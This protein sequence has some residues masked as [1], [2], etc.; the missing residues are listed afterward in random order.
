MTVRHSWVVALLVT[1]CH[2]DASA[3]YQLFS[4]QQDDAMRLCRGDTT[5]GAAEC[6]TGTGEIADATNGTAPQWHG[7][8]ETQVTWLQFPAPFGEPGP[9]RYAFFVLY[10]EEQ[11]RI[12]VGDT[13]GGEVICV[14][15]TASVGSA[16]GIQ[17]PE[18]RTDRTREVVRWRFFQRRTGAPGTF[19]FGTY[20]RENALRMCRMETASGETVCVAG[21]QLY[22]RDPVTR[23]PT[24]MQRKGTLR[25]YRYFVPR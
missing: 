13:A 15:G 14:N 3:N 4:Y 20:R 9:K 8:R 1:L 10:H 21:T 25:W 23:P 24:W 7:V 22:A 18:Y 11:P 17:R 6:T 5:T 19:S 12:C 2:A 16:L